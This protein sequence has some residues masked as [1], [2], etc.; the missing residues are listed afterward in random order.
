MCVVIGDPVS[1]AMT[2]ARNEAGVGL[3]DADDEDERQTWLKEIC[4]DID[5]YFT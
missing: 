3:F 1:T 5:V 2:P 4:D